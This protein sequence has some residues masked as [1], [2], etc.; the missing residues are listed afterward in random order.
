MT[1]RVRIENADTSTYKVVVQIWDKG[2]PASAGCV[3]P[4]VLVREI[5]LNNPADMTPPDLFITSSRYLQVKEIP[6]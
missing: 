4:D 3:T 1:K 5:F 6:A 2:I